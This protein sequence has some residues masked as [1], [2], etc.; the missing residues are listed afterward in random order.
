MTIHV[1]CTLE[2][3]LWFHFQRRAICFQ[4]KILWSIEKKVRLVQVRPRRWFGERGKTDCL[5]LVRLKKKKQIGFSGRRFGFCLFIVQTCMWA[6]SSDKG[7]KTILYKILLL[8]EGNSSIFLF[9]QMQSKWDLVAHQI[10]T[11]NLKFKIPNAVKSEFEWMGVCILH[12]D[13]PVSSTLLNLLLSL[14]HGHKTI[15]FPA[16]TVRRRKTQPGSNL[17]SVFRVGRWR[18]KSDVTNPCKGR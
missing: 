3:K 7:Y 9:W 10:C 1:H 17:F 8:S 2:I 16:F 11:K 5:L 6:H 13:A 12:L 14:T 15:L 18:K 4:T